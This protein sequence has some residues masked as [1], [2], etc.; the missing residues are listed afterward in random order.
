MRP[1]LKPAFRRF[2]RDRRTV[3]FG[4]DPDTSTVITGLD[5]EL[6]AML[7]DLTGNLTRTEV[8]HRARQRGVEEEAAV[9][10]LAILTDAGA[11]DA[12]RTGMRLSGLSP[13]ERMRLLPDQRSLSLRGEQSGIPALATRRKA[14]VA[15]YGAG[16]VGGTVAVTAAA[17]GIGRILVLDRTAAKATDLAPGGLDT[18]Q[19]GAD[20]ATGIR[21]RIARFARSTRTSSTRGSGAA[22]PDLAIVAP[23]EE[24][25]RG[26]V[27]AL[28]RSGIP[29]L[30]VRVVEDRGI[31]GPFVLPGR[32]SCVRCADLYRSDR[33][34]SY[35]RLLAQCL[36][37]QTV[38]PPCDVALAGLVGNL[39]AM[40]VLQ[41]VGGDLPDSCGATI[42]VH[43][44]TGRQHRRRWPTHPECGCH[45]DH[46][47]E[48]SRQP[49]WPESN[50]SETSITGPAPDLTGTAQ[51]YG[52]RPAPA[53]EASLPADPT[54]AD[55]D[56]EMAGERLFPG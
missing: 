19:D 49:M 34:P 18:L 38:T 16:R 31:V 26:L 24:P 41:Y 54:A 37:E 51:P 21:T 10:L 13:S 43:T 47:A 14:T 48:Q 12:V 46:L 50:A 39:A 9:K 29:H 44:P 33:D 45:W 1:L 15:V 27:A 36:S 7:D 22:R 6:A 42:E 11:L 28:V 8:L 52:V 2:W 20:R 56:L 17:A 40:H 5:P 53:V 23:S 4:V 25:D 3:Q 30:V 32:T 55:F 35:P